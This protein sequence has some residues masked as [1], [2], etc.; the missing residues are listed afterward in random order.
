MKPSETFLGEVE[1]ETYGCATNQADSEFMAGLL[2]EKGYAIGKDGD[3]LVINTCTVKTPTER[4]IIKRLKK[5]RNSNRRVIV[6]GCLPR[7]QPEIVDEFPEFSFLGTNIGDI[8]EAVEKE[9]FVR[10]SD[11]GCR[12]KFPRKRNN[13]V[14]GIIPIAQGCVG[15][16][17][18][19]IVRR[20]RGRLHSYRPELILADVRKAISEGVREFWFTAQDTGAYGKD[21]GT[22]LPE[23]L[24][25]VSKIEGE[26]MVRVGMMNPDHV[27][28]FLD[29]L[30]AA[31]RTE[32][33]YKFLHIPLQSGDDRVLRDMNR[34]YTAGDFKTIIK[35]FRSAFPGITISTDVILGFPTESEEAFKNTLSLLKETE[36]EVLNISR[37]WLRPGTDAERLKQ[38]P[39][40]IS[41]DR[42]RLVN[43]VF[44]EYALRKNQKWIGWEGR[45]LVSKISRGGY[46]ARNSAYK[47]IVIHSERRLRGEFIW[48][49]IT[50]ATYYNLM[51]E[52]IG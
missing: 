26:F 31:Y 2:E 29:E 13:P 48:V 33:I 44:K 12:F 34:H 45:V 16:C 50:D 19:C 51:G 42:S 24:G 27:L 21:T 17:S 20:A 14:V 39:T 47:P 43:S 28:E 5:L 40:R 52:V 1:I 4:K 6:T 49:R 32:K 9:R 37:F 7:A 35:E 46:T 11:G 30:I 38:L 25:R 3:I 18:Y 8:P 22:S 41:K 23:L 10:I 36:P 15:N